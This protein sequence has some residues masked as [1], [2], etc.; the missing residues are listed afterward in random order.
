[1]NYYYLIAATNP[2]GDANTL[3]LPGVSADASLLITILNLLFYIAGALAVI[4]LLV[5]AFR[6]VVS[7]GNPENTKKAKN[8]IAAALIGLIVA[9]FAG[10]IVNLVISFF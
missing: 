9:I 7:M 5:G 8:T 2:L 4:M 10:L 1:M 3:G 6:Y